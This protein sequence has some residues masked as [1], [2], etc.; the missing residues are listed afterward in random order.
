MN[1]G[2][3]DISVKKFELVLSRSII[4]SMLFVTGFSIVLSGCFV[5]FLFDSFYAMIS[6]LVFSVTLGALINYF[7]ST[8]YHMDNSYLGFIRYHSF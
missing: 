7:L 1:N 6:G 8:A 5:Y 2:K 3:P 4:L